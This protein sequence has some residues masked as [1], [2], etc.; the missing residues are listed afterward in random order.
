MGL[1]I[2]PGDKKL[3][4]NII[5][6]ISVTAFFIY[7][8]LKAEMALKD[9]HG[10]EWITF[11]TE[12]RL[13]FI[14][15]GNVYR[16]NL[17]DDTLIKL[18]ETDIEASSGDIMDIA[19]NSSGNIFL[20][21]PKSREVHIYSPSGELV[22]KLQGHFKE[23]A[24][25]AVDDKTIYLAD[26]QGNRV[27]ALNIENGA[28]LWIDMDY[29]IPDSLDVRDVIVYVSDKDKK[30]VRLLNKED[31]Q[32][33]DNI[34]LGLSGY[35]YGSTILSLDNNE[36]LLAQTYSR[37]GLLHKFS[38]QGKIIQTIRGPD[39]FSPSDLTMTPKGDIVVTDDSN[40][41]FYYVK[42]NLAS[43]F[44]FNQ[45]EKLFENDRKKKLSLQRSS[46]FSGI[47]LIFCLI[48]LI[49]IFVYYKK[50]SGSIPVKR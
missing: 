44:Q 24:K 5:L 25:I 15:Q 33:I 18:I 46:L 40:F 4:L 32:V 19:V 30:L 17:N 47:V 43:P 10:A 6:I 39:G 14:Y 45:V 9:I 37:N 13:Y 8:Y 26:M 16:L 3:M 42:G 35:T 21:D 50:S 48:W 27:I 29:L 2:K 28:I 12:G 34:K 22:R 11:D 31:G 38:H 41:S 1:V 23:N 20:T 36:I 7:S 49:G